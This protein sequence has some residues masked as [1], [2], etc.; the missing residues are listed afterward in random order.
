MARKARGRKTFERSHGE[1]RRSQLITTYGPGAM[2]DLVDEAV[3]IGGLD[4]WSYD[5]AKGYAE[6][7]EPRLRDALAEKFEQ[8]GRKLSIDHPF[9]EPSAGDD[10]N[11]SRSSGIAALEFPRWF[12]CQNPSC[13]ALVKSNSLEHKKERYW[14]ACERNK[15]RECVP[16]QSWWR[17]ARATSMS[18]RGSRLPMATSVGP[19]PRLACD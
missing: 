4:F 10:R 14:H 16:V 7:E 19:V 5:R 6:I 13:R 9:R 3:L 15:P 11:P 12:V 17:A 8:A 2:V 18:S 1:I